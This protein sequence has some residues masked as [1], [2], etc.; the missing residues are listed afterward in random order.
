MQSVPDDSENS[1]STLIKL[2]MALAARDVYG[3]PEDQLGP[4]PLPRLL[5]ALIEAAHSVSA[6]HFTRMLDEMLIGRISPEMIVDVYLPAV[7]RQLGED[8]ACDGI[9]WTDV[10]IGCSRIQAALRRFD[11]IWQDHQPVGQR[12]SC[13]V[14]SPMGSQHTLGATLLASQMRRRGISIHIALGIDPAGI[15]GFVNKKHYNAVFISASASDKQETLRDLVQH[16]R[17]KK[18]H[19]PVLIGGSALDEYPELLR[20]TGADFATSD[21]N[22][23]LRYCGI[24]LP[25][26]YAPNQGQ[27]WQSG[28]LETSVL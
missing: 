11:P 22:E 5:A 3:A 19:M 25:Y 7:A 21:L 20:Q 8:W 14:V 16:A 24:L 4:H 12:Y 9:R 28:D 6:L 26:S 10:T 13:L 23:A 1:V 2:D 27:T 17:K 15:E 18:A